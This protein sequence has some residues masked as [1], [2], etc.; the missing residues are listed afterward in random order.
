MRTTATVAELRERTAPARRAGLSIGLV[1][2]MGAFHDGHLSL[3][4]RAR[5]QCDLV[6]VS[7]FVNPTQFNDAGDLDALPAR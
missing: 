5:E 7:L 4:G 3:M 6:V 1:P 2:T